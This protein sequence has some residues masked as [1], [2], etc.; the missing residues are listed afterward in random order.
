MPSADQIPA[1]RSRST[2][3]WHPCLPSV[4]LSKNGTVL[5]F[6]SA[7]QL[8]HRFLTA[9]QATSEPPVRLW[10]LKPQRL[11]E[12]NAEFSTSGRAIGLCQT[13]FERLGG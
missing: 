7:L 13:R 10:A 11:E 3:R 1:K 8:G 12:R 6:E 5:M 2:M 4:A 9:A